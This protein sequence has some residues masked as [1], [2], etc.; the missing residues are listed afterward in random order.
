MADMRRNIQRSRSRVSRSTMF[1]MF[2][3][4]WAWASRWFSS[5]QKCHT[6]WHT[7]APS[8]GG[9][10]GNGLILAP[11][12][13]GG[14]TTQL[15]HDGYENQEEEEPVAKEF[16][17]EQRDRIEELVT[18]LGNALGKNAAALHAMVL[19]LLPAPAPP[20]E[21]R[22]ENGLW[23]RMRTAR[24]ARDAASN[25]HGKAQREF[26]KC[27][28][29]LDVAKSKLEQQAELLEKAKAEEVE[30]RSLY[31]ATFPGRDPDAAEGDRG[32]Q[33]AGATAPGTPTGVQPGEGNVNARR[34]DDPMGFDA[35]QAGEDEI[36]RL[37]LDA[38]EM[39]QEVPPELLE[40]RAEARR[41]YYAAEL[42]A[43][44]S[45]HEA[46]Q[47]KHAFTDKVKRF[48]AQCYK[49]EG[50]SRSPVEREGAR[51]VAPLSG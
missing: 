16:S 7:G 9:G 35:S 6:P 48:R 36:F 20:P 1:V 26:D 18:H 27:Q 23:K 34:P 39:S 51:A 11:C 5:C 42:A 19:P 33:G 4:I 2:A 22:S 29:A 21:D 45:A 44:Q 12:S 41:Q 47:A 10:G 8:W 40:E 17:Q 15:T 49:R 38:E 25:K 46:A 28:K 50:R 14:A 43:K 24:V 13:N 30:A 32:H 31:Q 3:A 37:D